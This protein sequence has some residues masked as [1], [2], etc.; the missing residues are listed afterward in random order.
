MSCAHIPLSTRWL[1]SSTNHVQ[2]RQRAGRRALA[3]TLPHTPRRAAQR[4]A[5][6]V[7]AVSQRAHIFAPLFDSGL[8]TTGL[9]SRIHQRARWHAV[10]G[11][12]RGLRD[13]FAHFFGIAKVF[14]Y[15]WL[16]GGA[17]RHV[18][19]MSGARSRLAHA[20]P[21]FFRPIFFFP[22]NFFSVIFFQILAQNLK[23]QNLVQSPKFGKIQN[24]AK[25]P[26]KIPKFKF[27][28]KIQNLAWDPK[29]D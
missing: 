27:F 28:H 26:L 11:H 5:P 14:R 17:T 12:E 21:F 16:S 25:R 24:L 18:A 2:R 8:Q 6:K 29:F 4:A 23:F 10:R 3:P 19:L 7:C 15:E 20:R 1:R 22:P 9:Q 13:A